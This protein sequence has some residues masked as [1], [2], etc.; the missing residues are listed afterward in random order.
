VKFLC[1]RM[2]YVILQGHWC[3]ITVVK[4][5]GPTED[6]IDYMKDTFYE[7]LECVLDTFFNFI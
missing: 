5:H 1:D 7:E 2:S 3:G 4:V 6:K